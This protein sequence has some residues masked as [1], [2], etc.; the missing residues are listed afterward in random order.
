MAQGAMRKGRP[1]G[2]RDCDHEL[3]RAGQRNATYIATLVK[4]M[5]RDRGKQAQS[6]RVVVVW[7]GVSCGLRR[8]RRG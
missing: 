6:G 8:S 3:R 7:C 5:E 4:E 1:R 2:D